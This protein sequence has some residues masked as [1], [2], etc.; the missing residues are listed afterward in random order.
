ME[1]LRQRSYLCL[2]VPILTTEYKEAV[3]LTVGPLLERS[4]SFSKEA[5]GEDRGQRTGVGVT[6]GPEV[7]W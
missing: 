5:G 3:F 1:R 6:E 7:E 4:L 2:H